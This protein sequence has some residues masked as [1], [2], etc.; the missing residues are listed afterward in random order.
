M[1]EI[2]T[3]MNKSL[4]QFHKE[5]SSLRTGRAHPSLLE[6]I[7]VDAY[8]SFMPIDQLAS[9]SVIETR[10][11]SIQVWDATMVAA[12]EKAISTSNLGL[13]PM[14]EGQVIRIQ[15]P[16]MTTERRTEIAKTAGKYA[17]NCR[18][19]MRQIRREGM[20]VIKKQEK[21]S[22]ISQD[23]AR[24]LSDDL[25]KITDN[26]IAKVDEDLEQKKKDITTT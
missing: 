9:V 23:E 25:Q 24:Q 12:V 1:T 3:K 6:V 22:E 8:G 19:S 11:L 10:T 26:F 5:L 14:T 18:V 20:D 17:E 13:V 16:E 7:R 4:E 21:N 15:L 2:E